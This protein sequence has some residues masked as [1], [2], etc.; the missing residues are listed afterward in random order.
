MFC[1]PYVRGLKFATTMYSLNDKNRDI[2]L[3]VKTPVF[4]SPVR[5]G[6]VFSQKV[7]SEKDFHKSLN[8]KEMP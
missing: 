3:T 8:F 6:I 5:E 1:L 7:Y 4:E 2:K